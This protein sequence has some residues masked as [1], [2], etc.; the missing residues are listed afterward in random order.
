MPVWTRSDRKSVGEK[1]FHIQRQDPFFDEMLK[2]V[3]TCPR[4]KRIDGKRRKTGKVNCG[5]YS[6][7]CKGAQLCRKCIRDNKDQDKDKFKVSSREQRCPRCG[8]ELRDANNKPIKNKVETSLVIGGEFL[9][10][11]MNRTTDFIW[12]YDMSSSTLMTGF[13]LCHIVKVEGHN[14]F[15]I[16]LTCSRHQR[17]KTMLK[18]AIRVAIGARCKFIALRAADKGLIELYRKYGFTRES[19]QGKKH[20]PSH[21]QEVLDRNAEDEDGVPDQGYWMSRRI[22]GK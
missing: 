3:E 6:Y 5:D 17:F 11:S 22:A 4:L 14:T 21:L 9:K 12:C 13:M 19:L 10:E 15:Y 20:S 8:T 1:P 16:D 18:L 2:Q 7:Q